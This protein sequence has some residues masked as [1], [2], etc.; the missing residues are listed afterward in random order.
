MKGERGWFKKKGGER[1]LAA[2][3]HILRVLWNTSRVR[4]TIFSHG[5]YVGGVPL[6][7]HAATLEAQMQ[8]LMRE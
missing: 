3:Y 1:G 2:C 8:S 4:A 5:C 7:T 6:R